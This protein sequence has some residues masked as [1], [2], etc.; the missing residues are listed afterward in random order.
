MKSAIYIFGA[1]ITF[2][3]IFASDVEYVHLTQSKPSFDLAEGEI[4]E[5]LNNNRRE[6]LYV[7]MGDK[8]YL[9]YLSFADLSCQQRFAGP[10]TIRIET[11]HD[12][13]LAT[14]K[15]TRATTTTAST[16]PSTT[17]YT[18]MDGW[19]FF[20]EFPWVFS[21]NNQSWYYLSAM[22]PGIFAYNNSLPGNGWTVLQGQGN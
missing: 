20:T 21:N 11:P 9:F 3:C 6:M 19:V 18:K 22:S 10:A 4:A 15:I 14:F 17:D 2:N 16:Q 1:F 8:E 12:E 7:T 5:I 13:C